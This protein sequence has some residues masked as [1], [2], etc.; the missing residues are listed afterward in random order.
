MNRILL[1]GSPGSGKST[2]SR[3]IGSLLN[4]PVIHLDAYYWKPNWVAT[5]D[6]EWAQIVE[7]LSREERWIIDG[8]YSRTMDIRLG[9]ADTVILMDTPTWLCIYRVIKRRIM[10]HKKTR[11]DLNEGCPEQLD[12]DFLKWVW[13]YRKRSR[14][15]TLHKLEQL[16]HDKQIYIVNNRKQAEALLEKIKHGWRSC[17]G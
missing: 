15:N 6:D 5:P 14:N 12:L 17:N 7:K 4:L 3:R 8:N 13:K 11:P 1:L 10:Y 16:R 2:L 9:R